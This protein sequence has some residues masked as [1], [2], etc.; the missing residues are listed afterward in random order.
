MSKY[1][2]RGTRGD[3][4]RE[5]VSTR[6]PTDGVRNYTSGLAKKP[7]ISPLEDMIGA[8]NDHKPEVLTDLP[9]S[10]TGAVILAT[11]AIII[12]AHAKEG[13][14]SLSMTHEQ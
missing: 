9:I 11:E 2:P 6:A 8:R 14:K 10:S 1:R 13:P 7:R 5:V 3:P 4:P 12:I